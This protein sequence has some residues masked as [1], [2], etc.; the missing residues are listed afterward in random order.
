MKK[1]LYFLTVILAPGMLNLEAADQFFSGSGTALDS[2]SYGTTSAGPFTSSFTNGNTWN[3]S[4]VA[5]GTGTGGTL[6]VVGMNA[7]QNF[8]V[9]SAAGILS[10]SGTVSVS[11][12]V[13]LDLGA[14][15]IDGTTGFTKAGTGK[16]V[17]SGSSTISGTANI[18]AGII[19]ATTSTSALGTAVLNFSGSGATLQLAND[20]GLNFGRN[21]VDN[22]VGANATIVSDRLTG[23]GAGVTHTLG[24]LTIAS[25]TLAIQVGSN[26][27]SG[28]A[29]VTFAG[30][31][32]LGGT[33]PIFDVQS[34][35]LLT[36]SAVN[37]GNPTALRIIKTVGAGDMAVTGII[38]TGSGGVNQ[39]GT[40]KLTLSGS[41]TFTGATTVTSGTLRATT[42]AS[43]LGAGSLSLAG[44]TL[45]LANNTGLNFA[46]NTTVSGNM[47]ITSDRLASGA[48]VTHSLG[49]LAMGAQT[50][51]ITKGT[52]VSSGTAGITFTGT[53]TLS[54]SGTFAPGAG[55]LLTLADI[56]GAGQNVNVNGAGDMAVTGIIG[57]TT[58]G[59]TK[60]GAGK[61]TLSGSNTYT[62]TTSASA[63]TLR[64]TTSASA[65]GTGALALSGAAVELANDTGLN[66]GNNTTISANTTFTLDRLTNG[67]GVTQTLG[68]LSIGA[69]QISLTKGTNVT[70]G[71]AGLTFGAAT[72]TGG[73]T[74]TSGSSTLLT[75]GAV[76]GT[77]T[78]IVNGP[79][80][81]AITGNIATGTSG[82]LKS[83]GIATGLLTLS[84]SNTYSGTTSIA[85]GA[86]RATTNAS[87]LG[88]GALALSGGS[89][90]LAND[91]GLNFGNN[92]TVSAS[93]TITSDRLTSG[94]GVT[95]T[96]GSLSIGAQTLTVAAGSNV[97][98]GT[99][100][101]TFGTTT[102]SGSG[103][104][105]P[106]AGTLLTLGDLTGTGQSF[107]VNG[108]GDMAVTGSIGI[109]TGGITKAG[110][111]K[112][113]LS[114]SS[115][116]TGTTTLSGGT[117]RVTNAN[118]MG[119]N[120]ALSV[121]GVDTLELAND[122]GL[123][124]GG[125]LSNGGSSTTIIS[126]DRET[127]GAGVSYTLGTRWNVA[128][129]RTITIQAGSNVTSGTSTLAVSGNAV[130]AGSNAVFAPQAGTLLTVN[131]VTT[132]NTGAAGRSFTVNGTG[133]MVI[134][135][136]VTTVGTGGGAVTKSGS[137][138]LTIGGAST[139]TAG[140]TINAGTLLL[141][142]STSAGSAGITLA[143]G[144]LKVNVNSG[145]G[146]IA[147][148]VTFTGTGASYTLQRAGGTNFSA[149]ASTSQIGTNTDVAFLAGT[150][151]TTETMSTS[152]STLSAATNDADR[153]SDIFT[154]NGTGTDKFA[155][156]L[157][158]TG[159]DSAAFIGWLNGGSW[160]NA[161]NGNDGSGIYAGFYNL[162]FAAFLAGHGGTFDGTTMLGAYG[163]DGAGN[164]WAV[165][166]HNSDFAAVPE[167]QTWGLF[168]LGFG[169]MCWNLRRRSCRS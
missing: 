160:V 16:L 60:A 52:N 87:A 103:T 30:T 27:T 105:A 28:T 140:T 116:Y 143:G 6:T 137:G 156:Q 152:F 158:V 149:Y 98:S 117:L 168:G 56:T 33:T 43:A 51:T 1:I 97:T 26:V 13:T 132:G 138:Q 5:S 128:A 92:T 90:Q 77:G 86:V 169:L 159:L 58:G 101:L 163:N 40:G 44:G 88:T 55:T 17:L 85:N 41:N 142:G 91:T 153:L 80:D 62:G 69:Q 29:G 82:I 139:Y 100:G 136:G 34:G 23:P 126:L 122:A 47:T 148:T 167:P 12:S 25:S 99:A 63:G 70:S 73:A 166:D 112:L 42:S 21:V 146:A 107:T 151:S 93:G 81:V 64:A 37:T 118:A 124:I 71:T 150:A 15:I 141:T 20:T 84:G 66:F 155:L 50:L 36:L 96:L 61:L 106:A 114:G 130:L 65:L 102:L 145:S 154:L 161:V 10:L 18:A 32:S 19:R 4:G 131:S 83:G 111:G 164:T 9:T 78:L 46:R 22:T 3:Y 68:S 67:A 38:N 120:P 129:S 95:H 89:L 76:S 157:T 2:S 134:T 110:A 125:T 104:F 49:S 127:A 39:A 162:S 144:S 79:G 7:T 31:T 115:T 35:A 53:T 74:L 11:P 135:S 108:A 57:T 8:T 14:E 24:S 113:T 72:L 59:I 54:G 133:D 147:N 119:A 121:T 165:L 109:T 94:N 123:S 45:E 75:L 48:G